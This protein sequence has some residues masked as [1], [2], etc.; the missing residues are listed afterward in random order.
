MTTIRFCT[1]NTIMKT[2][3]NTYDF[4]E[5]WGGIDNDI[6]VTMPQAVPQPA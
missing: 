3:W 1:I 6:A 2:V 4:I 5:G